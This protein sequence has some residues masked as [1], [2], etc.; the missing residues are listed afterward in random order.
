[1]KGNLADVV[2]VVAYLN[3]EAA[4]MQALIENGPISFSFFA[5]KYKFGHHST[6]VYSSDPECEKPESKFKMFDLC[7]K[8]FLI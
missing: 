8:S 4:L 6:G 1:M 5:S 3:N 2:G 7:W